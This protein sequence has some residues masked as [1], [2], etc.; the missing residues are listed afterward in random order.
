MFNI[1]RVHELER[2]IRQQVKTENE[3]RC[4]IA[5]LKAKLPKRNDKGRFEKK[6]VVVHFK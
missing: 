4:E 3:L 2:V 5:E 1:K 6:N